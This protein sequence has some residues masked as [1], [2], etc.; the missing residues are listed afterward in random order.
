MRKR[1]A[2]LAGFPEKSEITAFCEK[3]SQIP[4]IKPLF[5]C[6]NEVYGCAQ[7]TTALIPSQPG[8]FRKDYDHENQEKTFL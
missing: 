5:L 2:N 6:Y 3:M 4:L 1:Q 7:T 8:L